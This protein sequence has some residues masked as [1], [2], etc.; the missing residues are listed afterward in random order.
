MRFEFKLVEDSV[1]KQPLEDLSEEESVDSEEFFFNKNEVEESSEEE[2]KWE[3]SS[4]ENDAEKQWDVPKISSVLQKV[5]K[6]GSVSGSVLKYALHPSLLLASGAITKIE[7]Q[8]ETL[9]LLDS[10]GHIYI[11]N[12]E[13]KTVRK[14]GIQMQRKQLCTLRDI[15]YQGHTVVGVARNAKALFS[16]NVQ[17]S[18]LREISLTEHKDVHM[19]R[20]LR[21]CQ[22]HY[23]LLGD[24]TVFFIDPHS[25]LV[26]KRIALQERVMDVVEEESLLYILTEERLV[27]YCTTLQERVYSSETLVLPRTLLVVQDYLVL[28]TG[29]TLSIRNKYTMAVVK[30]ISNLESIT[31]LEYIKESDLLVYGNA[32]QKNGLRILHMK[33]FKIVTN[34][35][36]KKGMDR[37]TAFKPSSGNLFLASG[38]ALSLLNIK[39]S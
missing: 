5:K 2:N 25:Y 15:V 36:M 19:F 6:P 11:Y 12:T 21:A 20:R 27:K 28:S 4:E 7:A 1:A 16:I 8:G 26:T 30:E 37:V 9:A 22:G 34:F 35:Q 13:E 32:E 3:D 33:T 39:K 18:T 10:T 31:S 23:L 38:K 17:T 24:S 29:N 14:F